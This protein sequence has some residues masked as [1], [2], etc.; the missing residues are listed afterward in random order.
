M[1][2]VDVYGE[3]MVGFQMRREVHGYF[4]CLSCV[5]DRLDRPPLIAT[6][7][8]EPSIDNHLRCI[9]ASKSK[10]AGVA[11]LPFAVLMRRVGIFPSETIPVIYV[12]AKDN[13]LSTVHRLRVQSR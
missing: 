4:F 10:Q 5:L 9:N 6:H 13:Q 12:F 7:E 3:H 8:L 1:A 2:G 11:I